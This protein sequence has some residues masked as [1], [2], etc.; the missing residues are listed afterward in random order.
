MELR[1]Q[2]H[3]VAVDVGDLL[4]EAVAAHVPALAEHDGEG[5]GARVAGRK[6]RVGHIVGLQLDLV[7]VAVVARREVFAADLFAVEICFVE[8]EAADVQAGGGNGFRGSGAH[9]KFLRKHRMP[10]KRR[11]DPLREERLIHLAGLKPGDGRQALFSVVCGDGHLPEIA[12]ARR[13]REVHRN[14][15][16]SEIIPL[17]GVE[18]DLRHGLVRSDLHAGGCLPFAGRGGDGP[19]EDRPRD[20]ISQRGFDMVGFQAFNDH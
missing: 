11:R 3:P 19:G 12:G 2:L 6:K 8:A 7:L 15:E 9:H 18:K 5:V 4:A 17:P 1:E 20:L 13:E 14:A 10:V 16:R